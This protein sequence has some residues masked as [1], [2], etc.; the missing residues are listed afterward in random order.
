MVRIYSLVL[1][2]ILFILGCASCST[3]AYYHQSIS[4]HFSLISK[5]EPIADIVNDSA[6]D[7]KLIEQL[8]LA[9]QLRSFASSRLK[10]PDNNSYRSYVQLDKPYVTWNVFAAAEFSIALQQW[11]FFSHWLCAVPG[12]FR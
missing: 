12:L 8:M 11:C 3:I 2:F 6:Q 5:R 10:L 7:E 1:V 4:G 9:Q